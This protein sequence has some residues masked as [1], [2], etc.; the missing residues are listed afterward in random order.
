MFETDEISS[1]MLSTAS[2]PAAALVTIQPTNTCRPN[3]LWWITLQQPR[4]SIL[5]P[6]SLNFSSVSNIVVLEWAEKCGVPLQG[7]IKSAQYPSSFN[8]PHIS[9]QLITVCSVSFSLSA[10]TSSDHVLIL[11]GLLPLAVE[12]HSIRAGDIIDGL[13]FHVAVGRLHVAALVVILSGGVNVVCGVA[14]PVLP[15]EAPLNL[16]RL[17]KRLV[18]DG[19]HQVTDQLINIE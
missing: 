4:S 6:S 1:T 5:K 18:V 9:L 15:C 12:L 10:S 11:G 13:L 14:H 16:V 8:R 19:L 2:D 17:L 7:S 3:L